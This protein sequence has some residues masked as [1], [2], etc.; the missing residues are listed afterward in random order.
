MRELLLLIA[1][2]RVL[3]VLKGFES[4]QH[5]ACWKRNWLYKGAEMSFSRKCK[6]LL[7]AGT[8]MA[9]PAALGIVALTANQP[10]VKGS[11]HVDTAENAHRPGADLTDLYIYPSP[12]NANNVVFQM[13]VHG[14][15]PAGQGG[16]VSFDPG[17]LYQFKIDKTGDGVEDLVLQAKFEGTGP[18]QRV[19]IAGPVKPAQ[20]GTLSSFRTPYTTTGTINRAFSPTAGMQ[21][22]AGA[23]SDP[24]FLDLDRFLQILPD[25]G[26]PSMPYPQPRTTDIN[27][28]NPNTPRVNGFRPP[29]QAKNFFHNLNVL[30]IVIEM[31]KALIGNGK[32]GVWMTTSVA[33]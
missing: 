19:L 16:S 11:D 27:T 32:I 28:P 4:G 29:G 22:F 30:S 24:F 31:P 14:L 7:V 1:I 8:V 3:T 12:R 25:R 21:V 13:D 6:R 26:T 5:T 10:Q 33:R 15:I 2:D 17:V 18:N 23:R 20:I 9:V